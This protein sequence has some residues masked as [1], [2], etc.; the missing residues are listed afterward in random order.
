MSS[1]RQRAPR[2][3]INSSLPRRMK[4][5]AA[6]MAFLS[7][8][9]FYGCTGGVVQN[10]NSGA[11]ANLSAQS[12]TQANLN[13]NQ[14]QAAA[15][16]EQ[17]ALKEPES[18]SV[19]M[20]VSVEAAGANRD[21]KTAPI[22]FNFTRNTNDRRW[23]FN[24]LPG[25]GDLIYIE[26]SGLKYI[27]M[28]A[29]KRYAELQGSE[30]GVPLG[31]LLTPTMAIAEMRKRGQFQNVG[32]EPVNE[33]PATKYRFAATTNTQTQAGTAQT[34]SL[35]YVD[36]ETGLPLRADLYVATTGGQTMR[37]MTETRNIN[38]NPDLT[39]FDI[40]AGMRKVTQQELNQQVQSFVA[41]L[42]LAVQA[43]GHQS[44]ATP[45]Q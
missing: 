26:K 40:P 7:S 18:Y 16:G 29:Q 45:P 1:K 8:L 20:T 5:S 11:N 23:A 37:V 14:A 6:A 32:A 25:L 44:G 34:E 39:T 33:R 22:Q 10:A 42:Q 36:Q 13:A 31:T 15:E 30:I 4:L 35:I 24:A 17:L 28:P 3:H 2:A 43:L 19:D 9:L 27:V 12:N 21:V 41:L 38:L